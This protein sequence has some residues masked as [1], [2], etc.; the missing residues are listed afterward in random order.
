MIISAA[1]RAQVNDAI[2]VFPCHRHGDFFKWMK[3]LQCKYDRNTI[4]YG[5]IDW[6]GKTERFVSREE[7]AEIAFAAR[8]IP[9]QMETLYSESLW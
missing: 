9:T 5:F 6:D 8:Q 2:N 3:N 4:E 1:V 7:A